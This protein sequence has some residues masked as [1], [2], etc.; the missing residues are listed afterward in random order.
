MVGPYLR[1]ETTASALLALMHST[2]TFS[3][4]YFH[5]SADFS[6]EKSN[7]YSRAHSEIASR[8]GLRMASAS[9]FVLV[10]TS[11][12]TS[13]AYRRVLMWFGAIQHDVEEKWAE[14]GALLDPGENLAGT[15]Q[16]ISYFDAE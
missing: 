15:R 2:I 6:T 4:C 12:S 8:Y 13:S 7:L 16:Q 10:V 11:A 14:D 1:L 9:A 5:C 3:T